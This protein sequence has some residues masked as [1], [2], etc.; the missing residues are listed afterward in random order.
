MG[1]ETVEDIFRG[2]NGTIFSY[3]Q[4]GSG[5]TFTMLGDIKNENLKGIIPRA[6]FAL[7][8]LKFN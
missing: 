6:T 5:K 2:Y 4:T 7:Y 3:G 1:Y 8:I